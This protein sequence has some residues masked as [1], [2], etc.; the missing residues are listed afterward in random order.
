MERW[1]AFDRWW[2]IPIILILVPIVFILLLPVSII[3]WTEDL[4]EWVRIYVDRWRYH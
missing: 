4:I 3:F 2:D 1:D